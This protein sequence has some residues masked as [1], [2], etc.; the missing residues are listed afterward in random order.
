[1][2]RNRSRARSS[3][4]KQA[5]KWAKKRRVEMADAPSNRTFGN[6]LLG[7][8]CSQNNRLGTR[9]I[10]GFPLVAAIRQALFIHSLSTRPQVSEGVCGTPQLQRLLAPKKRVKRRR[11]V[12][13]L[14]GEAANGRVAEI[15]VTDH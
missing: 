6:C 3:A 14:N 13:I 4:K 9:V 7:F 2:L 12:S 15:E 11:L 10:A 1:V 5:Q 8:H